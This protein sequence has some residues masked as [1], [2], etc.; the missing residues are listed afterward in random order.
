[1][2][3]LEKIMTPPPED[4]AV[5]RKLSFKSPA[6]W[7]ATWFGSGLMRPAPGT[8]GTVAAM[9]FGIALLAFGTIWTLLAATVLVTLI[10]LWASAEFERQSG[11]HDSK[12][13]VIDEV[14]GM[15]LSLVPISLF[16]SAEHPYYAAALLTAFAL[17]RLFDILKPWPACYFDKKI[18]SPLGVMGDDIIAGFYAAGALTGLIYF[19]EKL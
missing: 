19:L 4:L 15:W 7:L 2:R 1:M 17:F 18:H 3:I 9:P 11:I 6:I 13:I 16:L 10:G 5:I 12:M 8:W 14:A